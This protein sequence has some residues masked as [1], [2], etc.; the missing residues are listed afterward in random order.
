MAKH[1]ARK[2]TS[3]SDAE[4]NKIFKD[5][6][7]RKAVM[8]KKMMF[9]Y[10]GAVSH[11]NTTDNHGAARRTALA[12]LTM[13]CG[14]LIRSIEKDRK[15]AVAF[16]AAEAVIADYSKLLTELSGLIDEAHRRLGVA[17][18]IRTD[19]TEVIE[20]ARRDL[21]AENAAH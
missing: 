16:A 2:Q 10:E 13:P 12:V 4:A 6:E 18:C 3:I 14:K 17:L 1:K 15:A 11:S 21:D 7:K 20:E 19:M 5:Y 9:K 8:T